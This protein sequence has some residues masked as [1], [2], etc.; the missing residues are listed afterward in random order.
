MNASR[1]FTLY[2]KGVAA[3]GGAA[4]ARLAS[5]LASLWLLTHILGKEEYGLYAVAQA[6]VLLV[7]LLSTLGLDRAL[8][9]RV[10]ALEKSD[11][12]LVGGEF[13]TSVMV[14]V[15]A[16]GVL[17][18]AAL[19]VGV[20]GL[21]AWFDVDP[22]WF[23]IFGLTVPF[24]ALVA[25][26]SAW[27]TGNDRA[28]VA[29]MLTPVVGVTQAL[30]LVVAWLIAPGVTGVA[31]AVV[32]ATILSTL[33]WLFVVPAGSFGRFKMPLR[34]DW[35]YALKLLLT[36]TAHEA[37]L[38][39]DIIM[40]GILSTSA[41]VGEY[42]V[43]K[44]LAEL[45]Q[46]GNQLTGPVFAPRMRY[47]LAAGDVSGL[48]YEYQQNRFISALAAFCLLILYYLLGQQL[49]MLF[50]DYVSAWPVLLMLVCG[51][52]VSSLFGATGRYLNMAGYAGLTLLTT[53]AMLMIN[54]LLNVVLIPMLG[55]IGAALSTVIALLSV[56][57]GITYLIW[58]L[59]GFTVLNLP[60]IATIGVVF[61]IALSWSFSHAIGV[62]VTG[63]GAVLVLLLFY[64]AESRVAR[65]L[66][67]Q[68][69]KQTGLR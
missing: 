27:Q 12:A 68:F 37:L 41:T 36:R 19:F 67:S 55:A 44:R 21:R 4:M 5:G 29:Q 38:R 61:A 15:L 66:Y 28:H 2:T 57:A 63:I 56:N 62:V 35:A 3:G 8:L 11:K 46:M 53:T 20:I 47:A 10:A 26:L 49:L 64:L 34:E 43:A 59:D 54:I 58:K 22:F 17:F 24:N 25:V 60:R 31:M 18:A 1:K 30:L 40:L 50:G 33:L 65:S 69:L 51:F 48:N 32:M 14:I 7:N 52:L 39:C 9:F 6:A 23:F 16:S 13:A 45:A 42:A